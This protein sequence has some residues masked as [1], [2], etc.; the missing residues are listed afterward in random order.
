MDLMDIKQ[1]RNFTIGNRDFLGVISTNSKQVNHGLVIYEITK[2]EQLRHRQTIQ[3]QAISSFKP[4]SMEGHHYIV[5][6][7]YFDGLVR[8]DSKLYMWNGS[9]F[10]L[11]TDP[12]PS[13]NLRTTG[14][15][16]VDFIEMPGDNYFLAFAQ[17]DN[18]Q[19]YDVPTFV[20]RYHPNVGNHFIHYQNL[21][22]KAAQRVHFFTHDSETYLLVAQERTINGY[23]HTNSSIFRWNSTYFE[24]FQQIVTDRAHDLVPFEIGS[25]FF[26]VAVNNHR[27]GSHN[28][29][30]KVYRLCNGVFVEH[31]TLET[32]GATMAQ[33]FRIGTETF[34]AMANSY[35]DN[36]GSFATTSDIYLVDGPR[37][38]PFQE[39]PTEKAMYMYPFKLKTGCPALAIA[40]EAG[41]SKLYKWSS[42]TYRNTQCS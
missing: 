12:G 29:Q 38:I 26:L 27:G 42:L 34:L 17:H 7:N 15:K 8:Y 28:I 11:S 35:D 20:F 32:R 13:N 25:Y 1:I 6:A 33:S 19:T 9:Q 21:P 36:N 3:S 10:I 5:V 18:M 16:D 30:S 2:S 14:V 31:D 40:N 22:T 41:K 24:L 37:F 39:I 23:Y 4:F